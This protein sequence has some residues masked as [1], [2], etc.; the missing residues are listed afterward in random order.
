M[1]TKIKIR[2]SIKRPN[3]RMTLDH[4]VPPSFEPSK[5]E[6]ALNLHLFA[7]VYSYRFES[8]P[9]SQQADQADSLTI[10][11]DKILKTQP[12][13]NQTKP[14][15]LTNIMKH[16]ETT[17]NESQLANPEYNISEV[18]GTTS[19]VSDNTLA[20]NREPSTQ[21]EDNTSAEEVTPKTIIDTSA[22]A[23]SAPSIRSKILSARKAPEE[24]ARLISTQ[25]VQLTMSVYKRPPDGAYWQ[26]RTGDEW[27]PEKTEVL[28]VPRKDGGGGPEFLLV[29]PDLE[30]LFNED[31]RLLNMANYYYLAFI[32]DPRGRV[33]WWALRSRSDNDWHVSARDAMRRMMSEWAMMKSDPGSKGYKLEKPI[34]NLGMPIWPAGSYED[35]YFKGMADKVIDSHDHPVLRELQG[36]KS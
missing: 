11:G 20:G 26:V 15:Q 5:P 28:L 3:S 24:V 34:D 27:S 17:F 32:V 2:R 30:P 8:L 9:I 1:H 22:A 25:T 6:P 10:S 12:K 35:W 19:P 21:V 4:R 36:R 7:R 14:H 33:A 18:A 13:P 31:P 16:I 29:L 23:E